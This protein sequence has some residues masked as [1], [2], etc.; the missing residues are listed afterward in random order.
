MDKI[1]S[2]KV[3]HGKYYISIHKVKTALGSCSNRTKQLYIETMT[4]ISHFTTIV[5]CVDMLYPTMVIT[6]ALLCIINP[7]NI[8]NN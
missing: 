1:S 2:G 8:D 3:N 7:Y 4:K 6:Y 5:A